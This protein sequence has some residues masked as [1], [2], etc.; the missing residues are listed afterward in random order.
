MTFVRFGAALIFACGL[1]L[2]GSSLN[3]MGEG[4]FHFGVTL[5]MCMGV[6]LISISVKWQ[7]LWHWR[8]Q[9]KLRQ[10]LWGL[11]WAGFFVWLLSVMAFFIQTHQLSQHGELN[12]EMPKALIVLGAGSPN[13]GVSP[14]LHA[15]LEAAAAAA[16]NWNG[17]MIVV[18]GGRDLLGRPC[19]EAAVM[20]TALVAQGVDSK[21]IL[22]EDK[23]TSTAENFA[24]SKIVLQRAGMSPD[25]TMAFVTSDFHGARARRIA[26]AA[27]FEHVEFVPASTPLR[28]RYHA[29]LREYFASLSSWMLKEG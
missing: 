17:A 6:A 28:Y 16:A 1:V 7:R 27:G 24:F 9:S 12:V 3:L 13:C 25:Q 26:V 5:P 22:L 11:G 18:S 15:R 23:S 4:L 19:T 10:R 2:V 20:R 21:R 14:T 8:V 29:W